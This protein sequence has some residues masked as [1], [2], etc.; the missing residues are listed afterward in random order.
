[1][2]NKYF[3]YCGYSSDHLVHI[4]YAR[5]VFS[6]AV[7]VSCV[8][9]KLSIV[10]P[11]TNRPFRATASS[12]LKQKPNFPKWSSQSGQCDLRRSRLT[13]YISKWPPP[14]SRT[15]DT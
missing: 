11:T 7:I 12:P 8:L 3:A 10:L 1:M 5:Y 4:I 14:F 15:Q 9:Q 2:Q 6:L 13:S